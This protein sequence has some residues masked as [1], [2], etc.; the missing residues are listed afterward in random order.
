MTNAWATWSTNGAPR[1]IGISLTSTDAS[2]SSMERVAL[3]VAHGCSILEGHGGLPPQ[4][5][6]LVIAVVDAVA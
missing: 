6:R 5:R 4:L 1:W 3:I 2:V